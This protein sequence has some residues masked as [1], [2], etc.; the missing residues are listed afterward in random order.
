[1]WTYGK[2][3]GQASTDAGV[4]SVV[5]AV[6]VGTTGEVAVVVIWG[7]VRREG[8]GGRE[9]REELGREKGGRA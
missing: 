9:G 4:D 1:L 2:K 6:R 5:E 3:S 7:G 8:E